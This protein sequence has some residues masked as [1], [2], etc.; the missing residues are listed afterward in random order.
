[1]AGRTFSQTQHRGSSG[2]FLFTH[3]RRRGAELFLL[4]LS[5]V[6]GVG[7]YAAVGLGVE[8]EIP[9]N[10]LGY[11]GWLAALCVASHVAVRYLAPYADPVLLPIVA[12]LNGL[13]LAII[14][15]IDLANL[16]ASSDANTFARDQLIWM[17]LGVALFVGVL[18]VVRDHRRL[19][20]FTYTFGLAAIVLLIMPLMPVLGTQINGARI[21]IH[22]GPLSFQPGDIIITQGQRGDSMFV[23]TTGSVKAWVLSPEGRHIQVREMREGDFFGEISILTGQ[24]RTATVTAASRCELLQL[25]RRTLDEIKKRHPRVLTVLNDFYQQRINNPAEARIKTGS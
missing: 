5:L 23:L 12:A 14:Y 16:E 3:R 24:P 7:G 19:Q 11:G 15:R 8:G 21:W 9:V 25:D 10:I 18:A 17:T 20:A 13:G 2:G 6:V 1:M 22:V 4:L